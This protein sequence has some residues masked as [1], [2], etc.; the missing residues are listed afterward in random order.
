MGSKEIGC[1][2]ARAKRRTILALWED[3]LGSPSRRRVIHVTSLAGCYGKI[4]AKIHLC[5]RPRLPADLNLLP[6]GAM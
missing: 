6:T 5:L 2:D 1:P 3:R 4:I